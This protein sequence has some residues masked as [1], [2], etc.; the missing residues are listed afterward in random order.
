NSTGTATLPNSVGVQIDQG[1][2][3]NTVGGTI[4][5]ARNLVSGNNGFGVVISDSGTTANLIEGNYIG[6]D[7]M[8]TMTLGNGTGIGLF[9]G[10]A[11]NTIG[12][13]AAGASNVISGN[14]QDGILLTGS[15]T[16]GNMV[17]GN[18]IGTD[19]GGAVA[20]GNQHSGVKIQ[21]GAANNIVGGTAAGAR[22]IISGNNSFVGSDDGGIDITDLGTTANLIEGNFI[23][24]DASGNFAISNFVAGVNIEN[25][26]SQNTVGGLSSAARN[27]ISG[28]GANGMLIVSF[29]SQNLVEGNYIGTNA[30]GTGALGNGFGL[31]INFHTTDNTIG[32]TV[33]GAGNV[34]S[35]NSE[36]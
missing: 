2:G 24:T 4:A 7:V 26:A 31:E 30:A 32:G 9:G 20:L 11:N 19:A 25:S 8:G 15:G 18:S 29:A 34:I 13:I 6:T 35:G 22:N 12:G 21:M 23:G 10:A 16:T 28:N 17:E 14:T 36:T 33:V 27:I 5:A 3:S 1:A